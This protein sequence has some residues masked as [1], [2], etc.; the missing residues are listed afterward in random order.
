MK[1][2][3]ETSA[4]RAAPTHSA[5]RYPSLPQSGE[6]VGRP[7]TRLVLYTRHQMGDPVATP[8]LVKEARTGPSLRR[9]PEARRQFEVLGTALHF[10]LG[11]VGFRGEVVGRG[12]G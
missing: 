7:G 4:A 9:W 1:S 8:G 10:P 6:F 3:H 5:S 2:V 12:W 11:P